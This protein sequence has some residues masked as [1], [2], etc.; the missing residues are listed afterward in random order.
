MMMMMMVA[1]MIRIIDNW[2]YFDDPAEERISLA[3]AGATTMKY[4]D[5]VL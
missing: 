4:L 5:Y 1:I 3:V 2:E